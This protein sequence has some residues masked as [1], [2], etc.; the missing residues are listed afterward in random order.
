M[1]DWSDDCDITNE[2]LQWNGI[3]WRRG[4]VCQNERTGA[5]SNQSL[6]ENGSTSQLIRL[7]IN[8]K[9]VKG[10]NCK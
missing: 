4:F 2:D 9:E 6:I 7:S 5:Q 8:K 1:I 3:E 10:K